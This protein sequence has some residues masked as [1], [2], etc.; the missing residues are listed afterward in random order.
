[1]ETRKIER[2]KRATPNWRNSLILLWC[3]SGDSNPD[4]CEGTAPSRQRVYQFHH[5]GSG[6]RRFFVNSLTFCFL[7][8][9]TH[10]FIQKT[11]TFVT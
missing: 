6:L 7:T 11:G 10:R 5:F 8:L 1:M 4:A 9:L 2:K 3:R